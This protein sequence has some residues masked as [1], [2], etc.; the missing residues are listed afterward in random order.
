MPSLKCSQN[1]KLLFCHEMQG[2]PFASADACLRH[3]PCGVGSELSWSRLISTFT[4]QD[5]ITS[6]LCYVVASAAIALLSGCA[7]RQE[8]VAQ[9]PPSIGPE[10]SSLVL[11]PVQ[12]QI[13]PTPEGVFDISRVEE[14]PIATFQARPEYPFELRRAGVDGEATILLTVRRDG[15]ICDAMV[16]KASDIRFGRS[17][18][19]S[20]LKWRFVP[21]RISGQPV[22]CRLMIPINYSVHRN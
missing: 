20:I 13:P 16:V 22:D 17:A 15:S 18:L 5:M 19:A 10:A 14:Q 8:I 4:I 7:T 9:S 1:R 11:L 12:M 6:R 2:Y 21:A 3:R